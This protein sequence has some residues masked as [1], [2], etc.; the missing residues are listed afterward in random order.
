MLPKYKKYV[1]QDPAGWPQE[2]F[3]G[4]WYGERISEK[5]FQTRLS[6]S[7]VVNTETPVS[8]WSHPWTKPLK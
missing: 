7:A 6:Y 1:I 8:S 5:E 3:R 4:S 2:N